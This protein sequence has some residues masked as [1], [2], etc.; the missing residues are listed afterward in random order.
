MGKHLDYKTKYDYVT[1]YL[2]GE[3]PTK[4]GMEINPF[5][6]E[7]I[8]TIYVWTNK[9]RLDGI[10]ALKSKTGTTKGNRRVKLSG[11]GLRLHE[12]QKLRYMY[13]MNE[14][15]FKTTFRKAYKIS[16]ENMDMNYLKMHSGIASTINMY[17]YKDLSKL[18]ILD[19]LL[20]F[21]SNY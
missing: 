3:S 20:I 19:F 10:E 21:L 7:P 15:Q 17:C 12:K 4:Q 16:N 18:S 2:N 8:N 11:Y 14:K 9:Y 13:G 5:I 1:R 6:K